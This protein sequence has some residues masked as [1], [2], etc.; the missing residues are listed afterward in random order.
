MKDLHVW[1]KPGNTAI[2]V[3]QQDWQEILAHV[4][5]RVAVASATQGAGAAKVSPKSPVAKAKRAMRGYVQVLE[6]VSVSVFASSLS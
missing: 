4:F 2:A 1:R 3:D 6:S 5:L